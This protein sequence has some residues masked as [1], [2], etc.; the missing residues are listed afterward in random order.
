MNASTGVIRVMTVDDHP[1]MRA[2]IAAV[3]ESE[4]DIELVAEA[5]TGAEALESYRSV[6]PD[7]TLMDIQMPEMNGIEAIMAIRGEF[8]DAR[9]IV[10]TTY[11]GDVQALRAIKAGAFGYMLKNMLRKELPDTIRAVHAGK[12]R[13]P[14]DIAS[15]IAMQVLADSLTQREIQILEHVSRG[16]ANKEIGAQLSISEDTVKA[17]MK[18]ILAKLGANDRTHAVIIAVKRGIIE[19]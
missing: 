7:V 1:L 11:S 12:R 14:A 17:H 2:G 9:I 5:S 19:V 3:L 15:E 4:V 18:S 13:I 6:R 8:P 10:L 16:C